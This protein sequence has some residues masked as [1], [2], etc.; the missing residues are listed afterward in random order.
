MGVNRILLP[1][2]TLAPDFHGR[3]GPIFAKTV[4]AVGHPTG[5]GARCLRSEPQIGQHLIGSRRADLHLTIRPHDGPTPDV[6]ARVLVAAK[7]R[8]DIP[9]GQRHRPTG[10]EVGQPR[11][12]ATSPNWADGGDRYS[13]TPSAVSNPSTR[14]R[15]RYSLRSPGV[16]AGLQVQPS[17]VMICSAGA[18]TAFKRDAAGSSPSRSGAG[19]AAA[20]DSQGRCAAG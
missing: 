8:G 9:D 19:R 18:T 11:R 10:T 14:A 20:V 15:C 2:P 16:A 12:V 7:R 1:G 4:G 3:P 13:M 6:I 5:S 17:S